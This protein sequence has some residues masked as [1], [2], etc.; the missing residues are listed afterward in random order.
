M[1]IA[2]HISY[3]GA[4]AHAGGNTDDRTYLME[5]PDDCIPDVLKKALKDNDPHTSIAISIVGPCVKP[6]GGKP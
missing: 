4:A 1:T 6:E 2:I 5:V 3:W